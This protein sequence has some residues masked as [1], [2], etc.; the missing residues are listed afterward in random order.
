MVLT[1][2]E[3]LYTIIDV[4]LGFVTFLLHVWVVVQLGAERLK[5]RTVFRTAQPRWEQK[6]DLKLQSVT[7]YASAFGDTVTPGRLDVR[8]WLTMVDHGRPWWT[9]VNHGGPW[10]TMGNHG[11]PMS[12]MVGRSNVRP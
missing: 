7:P 10:S 1:E 3:R 8:T 11:P 5:S 4:Y 6:F 9:M 12:T 2:C